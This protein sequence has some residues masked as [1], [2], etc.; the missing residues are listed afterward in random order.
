MAWGSDRSFD[1]RIRLQ[2]YSSSNTCRKRNLHAVNDPAPIP[3][4]ETS[5]E[6][7]Y[8][9]L[10]NSGI[11]PPLGCLQH[12]ELSEGKMRDTRPDMRWSVSLRSR[13]GLSY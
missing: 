11:G 3:R 7:E 13:G 12:P 2:I 6:L 8:Y 5:G 9:C 10:G 1:D 4:R